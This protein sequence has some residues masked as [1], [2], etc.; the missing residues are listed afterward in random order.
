MHENGSSANWRRVA[1]LI[2][3]RLASGLVVM[4]TSEEYRRLWAGVDPL[5]ARRMGEELTAR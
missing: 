4:H 3:V 2:P 1:D 5:A